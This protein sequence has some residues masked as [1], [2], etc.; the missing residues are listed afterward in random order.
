L[1]EILRPTLSGEL[2][3]KS[4]CLP[5]SQ[6]PH[7]TRLFAD[8]LS[9]DPKVRQF[10][11]HSPHLRE[12]LKDES[13]RIAYDSERRAKVAAALET[14]NRAWGSGTKALQN[15][16]RFAAGAAVVV[17]G[18]QVG[19]FGGPAF[20][21]YKALTAVKLAQ[22]ATQNGVDCVPIFWLA[23]ADHDLAEVNQ[24][25]IPG[26]EASLQKFTASVQHH[27]DA[28]VGTIAFGPEIDAVVDEAARLL[29]DSEISAALRE[30][31]R[32]GETFGSS[33]ARLFAKLF[34]DW[35]V[36]LMDAS[37]PA[38]QRI[39]RPI[40]HAALERAAELDDALLLRGKELESAGYHQQVK[41][42]P[43]SSLL[44]TL[45]NGARVV[46]HR[47]SNG[48]SGSGDFLIGDDKISQAELLERLAAAPQ[49]FSPNVLL[50]PVV[51][52]YLLPSL[53]YTGGSAEVAYFAQAGVV[54]EALLGRI[55][56]VIPRFSATL[57]E[58]KPRAILD[59]YGLTFTDLFHGPEP[60]R[61]KLAARALP[62]DLQAAF[63]R[64]GASVG[65]SLT[66]LRG[67]LEKLD[68]TLLDAAENAEAKMRHQLESLRARAARAELQK[69]EI[70]TRKATWLSN[71]LYPNK[72]LQEREVAGI[73]FASR[74]GPDLL[75][76]LY[77]SIHTDCLD[78]QVIT[79]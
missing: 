23:T 63:D 1:H 68:T 48:S 8:F 43:S 4:E 47:R 31:Y 44:F 28:S 20:S 25:S 58:S 54:Y 42:T 15:V 29:G 34:A 49:D 53:A 64:A 59:R 33:F 72:T 13:T 65:D 73:C 7:T 61:E 6:I 56:P 79:L 2:P 78:H 60:V 40:Y 66:A 69:S 77:D 70:I 18:Q 71:A 14:Q 35:G 32:P 5:Y 19:L 39:A 27:E 22:E 10:Y 30:C 41:V 45:R 75:R 36:V 55:T 38:L 21:I 37:D 76:Q 67:S 16:A 26:S 3:V 11:P 74:Y 24:V 57:V 17:T 50:R 46:I 62:N 9:W 12:W 52:D 51:Q